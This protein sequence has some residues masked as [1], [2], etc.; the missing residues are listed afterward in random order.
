MDDSLKK[1]DSTTISTQNR[2]KK[3]KWDAVNRC[4]GNGIPE[5]GAVI[6]IIPLINAGLH[7]DSFCILYDFC[8]A[9]RPL[10]AGRIVSSSY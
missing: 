6:M 3:R 2:L 1:H 10:C 9:E 5:K 7:K 4:G 8:R